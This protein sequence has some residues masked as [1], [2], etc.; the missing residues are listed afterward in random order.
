MKGRRTLVL[1]ATERQDR[2]A[3]LAILKLRAHGHE[4]V[5]VGARAGRVGDVEIQTSIPAG[6][7]I[8]TVTLYMNPHNQQPWVK[9]ILDLRPVRILFNP[10]TE[11]PALAAEAERLGIEPVVGCTLVMLS[12]G[13]F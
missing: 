10:G 5:A 2:Y 13:T 9:A 4:V 8:H 7:E 12:V 1:G 11:H 3:N 6:V